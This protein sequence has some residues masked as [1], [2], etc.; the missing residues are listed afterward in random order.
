VGGI[1]DLHLALDI[2][3]RAGLNALKACAKT[4]SVKRFVNT[5]SSVAVTLPK[6][7]LDH[8]FLVDESTYNDEAVELAKVNETRKKGFLVYAAMKSE[9]EKAMW[10]W[11]KENKPGF[12]LNSIVSTSA[13]HRLVMHARLT[14]MISFLMQISVP[15]SS[16][17]TKAIHQQSTGPAQPGPAR[18]S[19]AML[20]SYLLNGS[21]QFLIVLCC[22]FP[23]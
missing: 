8:D 3:K 16:P 23:L 22:T 12:V 14:R 5:S 17:R 15:S 2:G 1:T 11:M 20:E 21:Y 10:A 18:T 6:V 13:P 7:G 4:P 9:T 19:K